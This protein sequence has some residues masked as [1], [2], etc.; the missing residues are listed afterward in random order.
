M[1]RLAAAVVALFL[2]GC[3]SGDG[4]ITPAPCPE[5][6]VLISVSPGTQPVFSWTPGCGMQSLLVARE[7]DPTA[8]WV[9]Y[10]GQDINTLRPGIRYG[11][12]PFGT[13]APSPA[14]PLQT[15]VT[16]EVFLSEAIGAP[17]GPIFLAPRGSRTFTP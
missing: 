13:L 10:A 15:G 8:T 7:N 12:A 3:D 14:Q 4:G 6:G 1:N 17:G 16:Y 11:V 2:A 5:T 9:L